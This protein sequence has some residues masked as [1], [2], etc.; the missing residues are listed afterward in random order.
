MPGSIACWFRLEGN[1]VRRGETTPAT[2]RLDGLSEQRVRWSEV[3]RVSERI[4][5]VG[6]VRSAVCPIGAQRSLPLGDRTVLV[7]LRATVE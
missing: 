1:T 2:R 6:S 5:P 4:V 3:P 7:L